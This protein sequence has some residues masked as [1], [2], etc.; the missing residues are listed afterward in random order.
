M[1]KIVI[2]GA[3]IIGLSLAL[4]LLKR[5]NKKVLLIEKENQ[6]A[7]HQSSRNSGVMHAGLYYKPG[8]LKSK[9]CREGINLMKNYCNK[10]SIE[11][12]ECGK[13]VIAN[14]YLEENRLSELFERGKKNKLKGIQKI[15]N[16]KISKIEPYVQADNA[17]YVPEES[18]VNYRKVAESYLNE[19]ISYG[20]S[21]KYCSKVKK[22]KNILYKKVITLE[23]GEEL[24]ADVV[25]SSSGLYSDK[26]ADMMGLNDNNQ[27]ILPFRGEYYLLKDE[28]RYLVKGLIYPVPNPSFPF[29]GVHFTKMIDGNVEAGPNAVLAL[30]REGYN[31]RTINIK[32]LIES[33]SY[34]GL[35]KFIS[36]YPLTILGEVSR[37]LSK[38]LF[39]EDLKKLLPDVN[40]N[41]FYR[42]S[43]GIRAQLMN[44]DGDLIQD[45]DIKI[46]GNLI[47]ILNAPSPAA[48]SSLAIAKYVAEYIDI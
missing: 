28:F 48:T 14:N 2:I 5:G 7:S 18:I 8:S 33:L 19:I 29:L 35:R 3:G 38:S 10:H 4:E 1:K 25:I 34:E 42:G 17:I 12:N 32:E 40:Q 13:I 43:A 11:W 37:S 26:I 45:F 31:W 16:K 9:L 27:K 15:T 22:I 47:S 46:D 24:D 39:I 23:D 36:K 6:I 21:I 20:G 41:M 30:A 44:S